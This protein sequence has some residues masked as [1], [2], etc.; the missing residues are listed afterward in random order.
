MNCKYGYLVLILSCDLIE[1]RKLR[2]AGST[3]SAPEID[4]GEAALLC[5]VY[6]FGLADAVC[7]DS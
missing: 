5:G 4:N 3:P 7:C 2:N 6:L 1:E